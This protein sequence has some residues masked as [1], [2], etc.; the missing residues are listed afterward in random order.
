[1]RTYSLL[2]GK[3]TGRRRGKE[4]GLRG[5]YSRVEIP[6][7]P[8]HTTDAFSLMVANKSSL[9][10]R[11]PAFKTSLDSTLQLQLYTS[12]KQTRIAVYDCDKQTDAGVR[13]G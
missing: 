12:L 8:S 5:N 7:T 3:N 10:N 4:E 2:A 13:N 9:Y 1:M 6:P 11:V